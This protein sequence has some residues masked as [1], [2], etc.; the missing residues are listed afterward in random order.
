QTPAAA[1]GSLDKSACF[2]DGE[3]GK[4]S[5]INAAGCLKIVDKFRSDIVVIRFPDKEDVYKWYSSAAYQSL[6]PLREQAAEM[7]LLSYEA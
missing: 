2:D 6:I 4:C 1:D 5:L 7:I 3:S